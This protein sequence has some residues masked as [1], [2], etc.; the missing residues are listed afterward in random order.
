MRRNT[1]KIL[2]AVGDYAIMIG[3][4]S[5]MLLSRYDAANFPERF[6]QHLYTFLAIFFLWIVAFYVL[7]MYNINAPF[8]HRKFMVAMFANV[9]IAIT[10][11]YLF[12]D[13]VDITPRRNLAILVLVFIPLFYGW[14]FVFTR[15]IDSLA[16]TK[17]VAII[18]SDEYAAELAMEINRQKRQGFRV[19]AIV[20]DPAQPLPE[21]AQ[22]PNVHIFKSVSELKERVADLH[23]D[24]I[25]VS[26]SWYSSIYTDLYELLPLRVQFFQLTSFWERFLESIPIYSTKESWFLENFNRGG[27]KGYTVVKRLGDLF[28]VILFLPLFLLL[29]GVTALLVKVSSPGPAL[30]SQIRVGRNDQHYRIYKFRSM[31]TDAEKHG[32]QWATEKDP[33][34]TPIGRFIRATRL[35]EIP[36]LWNVLTGEMSLIGP[37]PE[38]PE[39]VSQLAAEIPHYHLRHLVRPG[40][41][42]WAQVQYRYGASTEDAAVKLTYDLYYVKNISFVLDVK[43]ALKTILTILGGQGR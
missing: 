28:A 25:I 30:F 39:F 6:D 16:I 37:R 23:I 15:I 17:F 29:A 24:S 43:I 14:R 13:V 26:D 8:N 7:E 40:L 36:Q 32:A 35:D 2:L 38:R 31:Y 1:I 33:R 42:G 9:A 22:Q 12:I 19:A 3:A 18:G 20:C 5:L 34:V 27:N 4:L 11:I 21:I 10:F 41:T